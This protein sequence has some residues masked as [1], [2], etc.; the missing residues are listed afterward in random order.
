[1]IMALG[2]HS[3]SKFWMKATY[4]VNNMPFSNRAKFG[5]IKILRPIPPP[6]YVALGHVAWPNHHE[7]PPHNY[8]YCVHKRLVEQI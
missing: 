4:M 3:S 6:G 5:D 1:M 8:M 2:E 7:E